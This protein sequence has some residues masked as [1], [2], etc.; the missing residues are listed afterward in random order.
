SEPPPRPRRPNLVAGLVG[1]A[2]RR[3]DLLARG[4]CVVV[5]VE[6]VAD[7][8]GELGEVVAE[9]EPVHRGVAAGEAGLAVVAGDRRGLEGDAPGQEETLGDLSLDS[10]PQAQRVLPVAGDHL[11][12]GAEGV[13]AVG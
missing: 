13:R 10:E 1:A 11:R 9:A 12:A 2:D 7:V 4:T 8:E 5:L 3:I 6:R